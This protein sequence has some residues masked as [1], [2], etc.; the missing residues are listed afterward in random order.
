MLWL[1]VEDAA[2]QDSAVRDLLEATGI[3]YRYLAVQTPTDAT[4]RGVAQRNGALEW[5]LREQLAGVVYFA[6]DDNAYRAALWS[7]L[8]RMPLD[9]FTV[10]P[11]GNMGY[12]GWEGPILAEAA[13]GK[14]RI[15]QWSCDFC[16]RRWNVDMSGFAFGTETLRRRPD[17]RFDPASVTGYLETDFLAQVERTNATLVC[18]P[19]LVGSVHVWHNHG[20]PFHGAAFYDAAWT[21]D[22]TAARRMKHQEDLVIG[23]TWSEPDLPLAIPLDS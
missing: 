20:V 14:A 18:I 23:F 5:I 21:T 15:E 8:A 13:E 22:G 3:D 12:F 10:F 9:S 7:H 4:H 19:D 16:P 11:V 17:L 2:E 1:V 6:D